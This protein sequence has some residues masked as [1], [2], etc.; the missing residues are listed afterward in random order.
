MLCNIPKTKALQLF[1]SYLK[2]TKMLTSFMLTRKLRNI[3][4]FM[5]KTLREK[6]E[7]FLLIT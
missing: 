5:L 4:S 1:E 3:T 2:K 7:I 6:S